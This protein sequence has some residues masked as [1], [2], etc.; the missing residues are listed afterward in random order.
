MAPPMGDVTEVR[1][2]LRTHDG[3]LPLVEFLS[4]CTIFYFEFF[5]PFIAL[6]IADILP[7][8]VVTLL[9]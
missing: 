7:C 4:F 5:R 1:S 3:I 8:H 9:R 2:R 6:S